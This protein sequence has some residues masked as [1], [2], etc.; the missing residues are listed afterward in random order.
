ME[1][2]EMQTLTKKQE[3]EVVKCMAKELLE[4]RFGFE[5]SYKN[6]QCLAS[7]LIQFEEEI[8]QRDLKKS[9]KK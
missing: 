5:A 3:K 2:I 4:Y 6:I 9:Y 8:Q 7:Y 1:K